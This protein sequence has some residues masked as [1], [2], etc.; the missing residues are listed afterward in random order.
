MQKSHTK[1]HRVVVIKKSL[2]FRFPLN[3]QFVISQAM[4]EGL[5]RMEGGNQILPF[6]CFYGRHKK[7]HNWREGS[8]KPYAR[9][10]CPGQHGALEA[11]QSRLRVG[12]KLFAFL[13]DV[14]LEELMTSLCIM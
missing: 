14:H 8:R 13:D 11:V 2:V 4:L 10:R 7:T 6:P 5:V 1:I 9:A 3:K 12:E